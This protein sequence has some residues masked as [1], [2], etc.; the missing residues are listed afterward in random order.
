MTT[1]GN[2]K[3]TYEYT[4]E[5]VQQESMWS[6]KKLFPLKDVV[7]LKNVNSVRRLVSKTS[8]GA[9]RFRISHKKQTAPFL[10]V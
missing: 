1:P 5:Y 4:K 7:F 3:R 10:V 8:S 6:R 2:R 9:L